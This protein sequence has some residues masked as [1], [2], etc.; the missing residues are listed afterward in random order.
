M[1]YD[2]ELLCPACGFNYLHHDKVEVFER[3]GEDN[4]LGIHATI[5][6]VSLEVDSSMFRNPSSRRDGIRIEFC[7][8]GCDEISVLQIV[9]HKGITYTDHNVIP[10]PKKSAIH[11][12]QHPEE[13]IGE[14]LERAY[15]A[16]EKAK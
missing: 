15:Q 7:C 9:Q 10:V 4:P 6:D 14:L 1:K 12:D 5:K 2:V 13:T 8:E 11:K 3:Y 16:W